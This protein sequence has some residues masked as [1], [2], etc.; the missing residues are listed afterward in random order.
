MRCAHPPLGSHCKGL[1]EDILWIVLQLDYSETG[2]V[3]APVPVLPVLQ[4]QGPIERILI[5]D[6]RRGTR[7]VAGHKPGIFGS[8]RGA[9]VTWWPDEVLLMRDVTYLS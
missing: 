5:I 9:W 8:V 7:E 2:V 6:V 1:G 3:L 4:D